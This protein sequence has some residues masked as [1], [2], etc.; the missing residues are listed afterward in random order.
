MVVH[1]LHPTLERQSSSCWRTS[2]IYIWSFSP[3]RGHSETY[4]KKNEEKDKKKKKKLIRKK[5]TKWIRVVH[6]NHPKEQEL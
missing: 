1:T 2:F 3:D 6:A 5:K 4:Q